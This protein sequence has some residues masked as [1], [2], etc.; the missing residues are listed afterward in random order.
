MLSSSCSTASCL[1]ALFRLFFTAVFK[2][3]SNFLLQNDP[4]PNLQQCHLQQFS[5]SQLFFSRL[6]PFYSCS[7]VRCLPYCD[8]SC[9]YIS[10]Y[11]HFL[12]VLLLRPS[13]CFVSLLEFS[14][15]FQP[16]FKTI[17]YQLFRKIYRLYSLKQF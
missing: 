6:Q 11:L 12:Q 16:I 5:S 8:S 3:L 9:L 13:R 4:D 15:I 2:L 7:S 10:S 1:P 17:V 14:V